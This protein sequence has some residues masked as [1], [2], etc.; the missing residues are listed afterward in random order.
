MSERQDRF[1]AKLR[2]WWERWKAWRNEQYPLREFIYLDETSVYS[3]YASRIGAIRSEFTD[4][5]AL[6]EQREIGGSLNSGTGATAAA[7]GGFT[8]RAVSTQS[9]QSQV[10][11]RAIVQSSF[12][13][14]YV[15]ERNSLALKHVRSFEKTPRIESLSGLRDKSRLKRLSKKGFVVA[16]GSLTRGALLEIEVELTTEAVFQVSSIMQV[17]LEMANNNPSMFG[18]DEEKIAEFSSLSS[19]IEG[20]LGGLVPLRGRAVDYS[21]VVFD[22][23]DGEKLIVHNRLLESLKGDTEF[24]KYPLFVVGVAEESLF[25]KDV[26]RVLFA[27]QRFRVL[28]R[29]ARDGVDKSWVPLKL[30]Q[31]LNS[32]SP[33]LGAQIDKLNRGDLFKTGSNDTNRVGTFPQHVIRTA[34]HA[35]AAWIAESNDADLSEED[36]AKIDAVAGE[37]LGTFQTSQEQRDAFKQI[38]IYMSERHNFDIDRDSAVKT[39]RRALE[40]AG[41]PRSTMS[42]PTFKSGTQSSETFE[43]SSDECFLDS[44]FVAIYW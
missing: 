14:L 17:L 10:V 1:K 28:C 7:T 38:E 35:Y 36:A 13:E 30:Q 2:R 20:L 34:L 31:V 40:D 44:E 43:A 4:T 5:L 11:S 24:T 37:R 41:I 32:V 33:D 6:S 3:L 16:P 23:P 18:R 22:P 27:G 39:R 25:W 29:V 26:R 42:R 19:A 15:K 8:A 12:K 9:Q 21:V